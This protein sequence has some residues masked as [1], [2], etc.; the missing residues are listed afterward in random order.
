MAIKRSGYIRARALI[1]KMQGREWTVSEFDLVDRHCI[2]RALPDLRKY[3][4]HFRKKPKTKQIIYQAVRYPLCM[5]D[6][7]LP[8]RVVKKDYAPTWNYEGWFPVPEF[9][10]NQVYKYDG[11]NS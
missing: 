2:A 11:W 7:P 5:E 1:D 8:F 6:L 9:K 10:V 4:L 3:E